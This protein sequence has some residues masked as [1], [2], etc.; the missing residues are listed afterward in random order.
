MNFPTVAFLISHETS[1]KKLLFDLG[2]R[3]DFWNLPQPISST[4]EAKVPGIKVD[5]NLADILVDGGLDL[6]ELDAAIISHHHYD[7]MGDPSTFPLGMKLIVGPGFSEHFLPGYPEAEASP[8][9]IDSFKGREIIEVEFSEKLAVAGFP[10]TDYFDDGSLFIL[11]TPGHAIGHLSA[12]VRT[13]EDTFVF[14]GGDICHFGGSFRPTK[15]MPLPESLSSGDIVSPGGPEEPQS[16]SCSLL[17]S[18]HPTPTYARTTPFYKP[19]SRDDSWYVQ[20]S[21]AL[22][23]IEH[24]QALDADERVLVLIAHDPSTMDSLPFFPHNN[25]NSWRADGLKEKIRWR[26]LSEL[27]IE[28]IQRKY[29]VDGTYQNGKRVRDLDGRQVA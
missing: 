17:T 25:I 2:C 3:K 19:C 11:N 15:H 23:S 22:E 16:F 20:P 7:H 24:L 10:A 13:T 28:G 8:A 29:L 6:A 12:L 21:Q 14:L 27:P 18:C 26:F 5:H 4:I 9:F 1:G